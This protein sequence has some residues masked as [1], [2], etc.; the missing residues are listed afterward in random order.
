MHVPKAG[1]IQMQTVLC[2]Y[3]ESCSN[4][5]LLPEG[6]SSL[7]PSLFICPEDKPRL[8]LPPNPPS[9][10]LLVESRCFCTQAPLCVQHPQAWGWEGREGL[11]LPL[12]PG[13]SVSGAVSADIH[14]SQLGGGAH[15]PPGGWGPG[16]VL[17]ALQCARRP[18]N[19]E[20]LTPNVDSAGLG[21]PDLNRPRHVS[22]RAGVED[23]EEGL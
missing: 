13:P 12:Q 15:L 11:R 6:C 10:S 16:K 14:L 17:S 4:S 18:L 22:R 21:N 7:C 3:F 5:L 8:L 9:P 23:I 19:K 1:L 20:Y 2:K